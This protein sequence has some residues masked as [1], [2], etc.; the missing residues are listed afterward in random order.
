MAGIPKDELE[1]GHIYFI[2]APDTMV[3]L[4]DG[5]DFW[6]PVETH[7]DQLSRLRHY[8]E[9]YPLGVVTP[10]A[11][12]TQRPIALGGVNKNVIRTI[13]AFDSLGLVL[14]D[15]AKKTEEN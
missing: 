7:L 1:I 11:K 13:I 5:E 15:E 9:G 12:I 3:G 10:I 8:D 14:L 4:W 2:K 6:C